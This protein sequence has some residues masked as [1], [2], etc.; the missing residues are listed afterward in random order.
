MQQS[1]DRFFLFG[2]VLI[3]TTAS[4]GCG[5]DIILEGNDEANQTSDGDGD[6]D[7]RPPIQEDV[8]D[9]FQQMYEAE[10]ELLFRCCGETEREV[11]FEV[12]GEE[13]ECKD[14]FAS[15]IFG[16]DQAILDVSLEEGR[17][18]LNEEQ[19]ELC[20]ASFLALSCEEWTTLEPSKSVHLPGCGAI[21]DPRVQVG[22]DCFNDYECV[23]GFCD[24]TFNAEV[25]RC[26]ARAGQGE[27]CFSS[28]CNEGMYCDVFNEVC[29]PQEPNGTPCL[30]DNE[31]E[32]GFCAPISDGSLSCQR[33]LPICNGV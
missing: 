17:A 18:V 15:L 5:R 3:L 16:M 12:G 11:V 26:E 2:A 33:P 8:L 24:R 13:Q 23:S 21:I 32:S 28:L 4:W 25:G 20:V 6:G 19:V 10:C 1:I 7:D 22:G 31:C 29:I 14:Q 30:N 27:D 9:V